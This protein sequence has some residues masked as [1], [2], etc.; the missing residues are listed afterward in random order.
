MLVAS[1]PT[2]AW[3]IDFSRRQVE[4]D[5]SS[6]KTLR[7]PATIE[8]QESL[9]ITEKIFSMAEP[10]QDIVILNTDKGFVPHTLRLKRGGKYKI[11]V[12]N[13]HPKEKNLSII[14]ESFSESHSTFF[15]E[16]KTF[17]ITPKVDGTFSYQCPE[18]AVQG[19]IIVFSE[20]INLRAPAKTD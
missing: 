18:T 6:D 14:L 2:G 11:H 19:K 15:G 13:V 12:V 7:M 20:N 9:D 1:L 4:F 8:V 17:D 3:E 10:L 5:K 16:E